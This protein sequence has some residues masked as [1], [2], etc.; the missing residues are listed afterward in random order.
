LATEFNINLSRIE[1]TPFHLP[2]LLPNRGAEWRRTS[3]NKFA[4]RAR[5][6]ARRHVVLTVPER[7]ALGKNGARLYLVAPT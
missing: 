5:P 1:S 7:N 2:I 3:A 4:T 6:V